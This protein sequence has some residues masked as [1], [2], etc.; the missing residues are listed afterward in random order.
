MT[1]WEMINANNNQTTTGGQVGPGDGE[2]N[3]L[4]VKVKQ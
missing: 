2:L 4:L 1:G 3:N